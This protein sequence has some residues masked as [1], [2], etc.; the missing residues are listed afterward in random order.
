MTGEKHQKPSTEQICLE[1]QDKAID[2]VEVFR[3]RIEQ[4]GICYTHLAEL[5]ELD[6]EDLRH[7]IENGAPNEID[8]VTA[9]RVASATGLSVQV[10]DG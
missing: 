6:A 8:L 1:G 2:L 3:H 7:W 4:S 5:T 9:C 10:T